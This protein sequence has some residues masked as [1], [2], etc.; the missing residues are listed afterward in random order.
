MAALVI[1]LIAAAIVILLVRKAWRASDAGASQRSAEPPQ[2][3]QAPPQLRQ[4]PPPAVLPHRQPAPPGPV[5]KQRRPSTAQVLQPPA[6][7]PA[8][9]GAPPRQPDRRTSS[10]AANAPSAPSR[11]ARARPAHRWLPQ[12][13]DVVVAGTTLRGGLLYVGTGMPDAAGVG[14][15]PAL[16]DPGLPVD[17]RNPDWAGESMDYWPSYADISPR[18]RG[19]YLGWL[20][21]GRANSNAYIGYVFLYFYG[22]ERRLLT[23]IPN[24]A[25]AD[26]EFAT[27]V[28]EVRR[29]L[30]IY[31]GNRSFRSYAE[32]L[33]DAVAL[34]DPTVRY[35]RA[36]PLVPEWSYEL[37]AD[38]K[39][40][41]A[42]LAV[43][44]RPV[45][46]D[47]ALSW[48]GHHP[49]TNL[50]TPAMRCPNEFLELF[51]RRYRAKF[52]EGMVIKPNKPRLS[53]GYYAASRG[54]NGHITVENTK[55]PDVG[56][57]TGP[58]TKL[59]DIVEGVTSDLDAYSR[60]LGRNPDGAGSPAAIALL[61]EGVTHKPSPE[62][63]ALWSWAA[64]SIGSDGRGVT[65]AQE[66]VS[67]WPT[68]TGKLAKADAVA[69]AQLLE[70]RGLGIEPDVRFGGNTPTP[71][72]SVVLFRRADPPVSAPSTEYA[73]ALAIINLGMLVAAADGTVSEPER[74]AL[75]EL[76]IDDLDLSEDE[77]L[78]L[79]AHA[80]LVLTKPPTP[81]V[82]RRRL[83]SLPTSRKATVGRLLTTIAA[84][85]GQVTP[86][87]IR[88]LE[89]LFTTLGLDP[90]EV[91][92]TLHAAAT[93]TDELTSTRIPGAQRS[94]R[95]I[96]APSAAPAGTSTLA[97]DPERLARTRAE[98][99]RVAAELAEIF[100]DDQPTPP[101]PPPADAVVG[102][103]DP[104]HTVLFHR[105]VKQD[106]W[107][108]AEFDALAAEIG[109][110]P[111]GALEVLNDAA[112][113][114]TDEPLCEG[115][116]PIEINQDIVKDMLG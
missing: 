26:A 4:A 65:S 39:V 99:V 97:L 48:Y 68:K 91:Y 96:P 54:F 73:A 23:E 110:M 45:P 2:L 86:D 67:R 116:D 77:R 22:L 3:R 105:L 27:L 19:A 34:L 50:R 40:G 100:A 1:L 115:S 55:L 35:D 107:S 49:D 5:R 64:Q 6:L 42:Q 106:T 47:W 56:K 44:G 111:D 95:T 83:E 52:G 87:E 10:R 79:D 9:Q 89:R 21:G 17:L 38:L 7:A 61:P 69:L 46:A 43:D 88:T 104:S 112:Y 66:L 63:E 60:Y 71:T 108:R 12:D 114:R 53:A 32:G 92:G 102:G 25:D 57:L 30:G 33:L 24:L 18:A 103:L 8:R 29:L 76:A 28:G 62:T 98:S 72:S 37:P 11:P 31:R 113:D 74:R 13:Q 51:T 101:P 36:A 15:E 58:I 85:D 59:R 14:T 90:G 41:L 20:A 93:S 94:G 81:A 82:L 70:H 80:A 75:R 16:I 84:A 109:L 78:R